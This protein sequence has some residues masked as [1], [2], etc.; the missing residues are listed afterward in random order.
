[1]P[2]AGGP[3]NSPGRNGFR[4]K[5]IF[6]SAR[7]Q[8]FNL[9]GDSFVG[10]SNQAGRRKWMAQWLVVRGAAPWG[11]K[12]FPDFGS[13]QISTRCPMFRL[14]KWFGK[15]AHSR[16]ASTRRPAQAR[17]TLEQLDDRLVPSTLVTNHGGLVIQHVQVENVYYGADWYQPD[18]QTLRQQLNQFTAT[19]VSGSYMS[20]LGEYGA[21]RGSFVKDDIVNDNRATSGNT[22]TEPQ[23]QSMLSNQIRW[24]YLDEANASHV[25]VVYLPPNV[26]S[27]YDVSQTAVGHHLSFTM[28]YWHN[29]HTPWGWVAYPTT[30]TVYYAVVTSPVGN[31]ILR[32]LDLSS[33]LP[34]QQMDATASHELAEAV[35]DPDGR[36]WWD[37]ATG[38]EIGDLVNA[39]VGWLDGYVVQR[40]WSN[41]WQRGE[42]PAW[43]VVNQWSEPVTAYGVYYPNGGGFVLVGRGSYTG[44]DY[45]C[46]N[47]LNPLDWYVPD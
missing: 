36:G 44:C 34:F 40:E 46:W 33:Y 43:D 39:Q 10:E 29:A 12:R 5:A 42:L 14:Q 3:W 19:I 23:I 15:R 28:T 6:S 38:K 45:W 47:S 8:V 20:M 35:T 16:P 21:G 17:L 13:P 26:Q 7:C 22:V 24:G 25:Y 11:Q 2:P 31:P 30:D 4:K 37:P 1:V 27:Q 32:N 41:A 9:G 18:N